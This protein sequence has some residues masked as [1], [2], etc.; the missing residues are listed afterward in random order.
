[1]VWY[2]MDGMVGWLS[3]CGM[4]VMCGGRQ[5][6]EEKKAWLHYCELMLGYMLM[7]ILML[8]CPA[9]LDIIIF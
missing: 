2:G 9:G 1:M 6:L 3:Q 4:V 8:T 7:L 5:S